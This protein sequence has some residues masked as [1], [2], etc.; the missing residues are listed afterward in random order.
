MVRAILPHPVFFR[1]AGI[2]RGSSRIGRRPTM[3]TH[4]TQMPARRVRGILAAVCAG[5]IGVAGLMSLA[6]KAHAASSCSDVEV[7]FARGTAEPAGVGRVG[8][9]FVDDLKSQL[10]VAPA[11][12]QL[13]SNVEPQ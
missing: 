10:G 1:P 7:V 12:A 8:Q 2:D 3:T 11:P 9:A 6:P 4:M 13:A 5:V